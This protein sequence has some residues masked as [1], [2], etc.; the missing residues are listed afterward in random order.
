MSPSYRLLHV[1]DSPEDAELVRLA[2]EGRRGSFEFTRVE[3]EADYTAQLE[4]PRRTSFSATTTC[5]ISAPSAR[6]RSLARAT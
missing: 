4:A 1:E 3:T 5:P 6:S 2:L